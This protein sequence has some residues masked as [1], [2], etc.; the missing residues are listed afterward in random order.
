M[1]KII[2]GIFIILITFLVIL[3][4][5]IIS[6]ADNTQSDE[7]NAVT[8]ISL[9]VKKSKI[10]PNSEIKVY[11]YLESTKQTDGIAVVEGKIDFDADKLEPITTNDS[12]YNGWTTTWNTENGSIT[13]DRGNLTSTPQE[14]AEL[15]FKVKE[16]VEAGDTNVA[17]KEISVSD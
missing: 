11:I 16:E 14:I 15:T 4:G 9:K 3:Q 5:T 6:N 12:T 8:K 17:F 13:I 10:T 1:E 2:K 7:E